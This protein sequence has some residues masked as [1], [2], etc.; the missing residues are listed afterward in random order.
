MTNKQHPIIAVTPDSIAAEM[1]IAPGDTLLQIDGKT[2]ED[3]LDY[4][5]MIA[6]EQL[7][8]LIRKKNGEEWLLEIEDKD[9]QEDIGL[10]FAEGLMDDYRACQNKCIFCFVDQMPPNLRETL[11]FKDDDARL[12]FL[13]GNYITL[14][15]LGESEIERIIR[16]RLAPINISIHTTNPALRCQ[17]LT[18]KRAGEALKIIARLAEA[19]IKMNGQ[20]VLCKGIN[21]GAELERTIKD[22][23][24]YLPHLESLSVVPVGLTKYR[25]GL[26]S[27][28]PFEKGDAETV[29]AL[30]HRYQTQLYKERETHFVHASDE[31]YLLAGTELPKAD[32]Y[33]G[34][35]QLENG[36]GML[37]LFLDEVEEALQNKEITPPA[38]TLSLATGR[39]VYPYIK[40]SAER[41]M[42]RF[43]ALKLHVYEI[44]NRF[45]GESVTV[46][47]LLCG[48]DIIEQLKDKDL[49]E[50]L[51]LP[52][53]LLR[54][55]EEVLL[56]G[57]TIADIENSLQIPLD[58]VQS[59]GYDFI[60]G[61]MR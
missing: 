20:I 40:A 56:D 51:L 34:Y 31:W 47:G 55:G 48:V 36:V 12:S 60:E 24:A 53:N 15:N 9:E 10:V 26:P 30:I 18:H 38:T 25:E 1:G 57:F 28:E 39:L 21:D 54:A 58:I 4:R 49:G 44:G 43:P 37:R 45:F 29:L 5:F 7:E 22:L 27:L 32:T 13:Q 6:S 35:P 19:E 41:I 52:A 11:Y 2:P 46:S 3:V 42:R 59:S 8:L 50:R 16:Y 61:I 23:T 33:D 17:M 14:T